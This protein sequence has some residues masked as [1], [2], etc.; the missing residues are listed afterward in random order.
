[1]AT[2]G[3]D[4]LAEY[5]IVVKKGSKFELPLI[6]QDDDG[7]VD[8]TDFSIKAQLLSKPGGVPLLTFDI[9]AT[10]LVG[11]AFNVFAAASSTA[12]IGTSVTGTGYADALPPQKFWAGYWD[13]L[14][15]PS[16]SVSVDDLCYLQGVA[17]VYPQGTTR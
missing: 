2:A 3:M 15:A 14:I 7:P 4:E 11:G 17:K 9:V 1:M 6:I 10:N 13:L 16:A 12:Q 5:D 8:L